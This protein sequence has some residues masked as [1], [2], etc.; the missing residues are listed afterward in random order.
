M[1]SHLALAYPF[2]PTQDP[3]VILGK[4]SG[5]H[6]TSWN[7]LIRLT[8]PEQQQQQT[9]AP[10]AC[11]GPGPP[12]RPRAG[13]PLALLTQRPAGR[14][15]QRDHRAGPGARGGAEEAPGEEPGD[16]GAR[17]EARGGTRLAGQAH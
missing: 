1:P 13:Q 6:D 3:S 12:A 17:G 11:L 5:P 14:D 8:V 16:E 15:A 2:L 10:L 4:P 7:S 9:R